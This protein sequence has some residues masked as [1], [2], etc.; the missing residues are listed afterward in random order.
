[1]EEVGL[2]LYRK[3]S[4]DEHAECTMKRSPFKREREKAGRIQ[5]RMGSKPRKS[6]EYL[7]LAYN[8]SDASRVARSC[9]LQG[10]D[11]YK[12]AHSGRIIGVNL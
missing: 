12:S 11:G 10:L 5:S 4:G 9:T 8:L 6:V 1:M 7:D 2:H 3:L